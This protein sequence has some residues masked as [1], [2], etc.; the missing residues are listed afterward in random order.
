M[1]KKKF[2]DFLGELQNLYIKLKWIEG[3]SYFQSTKKGKYM[4]F[5]L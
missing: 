4:S 5:Q 2:L 3:P 1:K